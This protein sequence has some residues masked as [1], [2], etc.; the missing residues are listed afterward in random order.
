MPSDSNTYCEFETPSLT[1]FQ[2]WGFFWNDDTTVE[3]VIKNNRDVGELYAE[4]SH[5]ATGLL[6]GNL[7]KALDFVFN[8]HLEFAAST[9][10]DVIKNTPELRGLLDESSLHSDLADLESIKTWILKKVKEKTISDVEKLLENM[11]I[12]LM[13]NK[14]RCKPDLPINLY[15]KHDFTN[16]NQK[17]L[18]LNRSPD[19]PGTLVW[20]FVCPKLPAK[21]SCCDQPKK[22]DVLLQTITIKQSL[23]VSVCVCITLLACSAFF[24]SIVAGCIAIAAVVTLAAV[25]LYF[26]QSEFR[27]KLHQDDIFKRTEKLF[28]HESVNVKLTL[29][30]LSIDDAIQHNCSAKVQLTAG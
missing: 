5:P 21:T 22:C 27:M 9:L 17:Y 23:K 16:I 24:V 25:E 4:G 14:V 11:S 15:K 7:L 3:S 13:S 26:R 2:R 6:E 18:L 1:D 28:L 19:R 29:G 12:V 8:A 10:L 20:G 30:G